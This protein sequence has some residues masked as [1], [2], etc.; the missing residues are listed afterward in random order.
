M[1]PQGFLVSTFTHSGVLL[2]L[3]VVMCTKVSG[4]AQQSVSSGLQCSAEGLII[5]AVHNPINSHHSV[6]KACNHGKV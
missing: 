5:Y 1:A 4:G 6:C 2:L 3:Q